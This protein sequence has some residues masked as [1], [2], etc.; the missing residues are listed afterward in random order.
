LLHCKLRNKH[1][2]HSQSWPHI[3]WYLDGSVRVPA[4]SS[5]ERALV[6]EEPLAFVKEKLREHLRRFRALGDRDKQRT[7]KLIFAEIL[8]R[9]QKD[10]QLLPHLQIFS[11][12]SLQLDPG[13]ID[14]SPIARIPRPQLPE[15]L[16][17]NCT[18]PWSSTARIPRLQLPESLVPKYL[19]PRK[20]HP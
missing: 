12:P 18:N 16:V 10:K 15:S 7:E 17:P 14:S 3:R 19:N 8:E 6:T 11:E 5:W 20:K 13:F 2:L 9:L 4:F 1:F